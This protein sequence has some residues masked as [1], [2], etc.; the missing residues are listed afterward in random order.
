MVGSIEYGVFLRTFRQHTCFDQ[1]V[2]R[3]APEIGGRN[4]TEK[5]GDFFTERSL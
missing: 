3:M 4:Q 2:K 5:R 1:A